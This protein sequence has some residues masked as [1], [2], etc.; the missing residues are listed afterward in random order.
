M[1][2]QQGFTLIELMIVVAIIGILAAVALPAYQQYTQRA[3]FSEVVLAATSLKSQVEVCAQTDSGAGAD[4]GGSCSSGN[5]GVTSTGASGVVAS[6]I[7]SDQGNNDVRITATGSGAGPAASTYVL[8]GN[9][10]NTGQVIWTFD[11]GVSD[12]DN[13]GVCS[14]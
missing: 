4:F 7:A 5:G 8:N 12:C 13:N 2:K 1:K 6:V 14:N 10:L 9:R 11:E 3:E